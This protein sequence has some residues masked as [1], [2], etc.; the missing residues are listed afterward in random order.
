[1]KWIVSLILP[2]TLL[3]CASEESSPSALIAEQ[4]TVL[5]FQKEQL[6]ELWTGDVPQM[7]QQIHHQLPQSL[8]LPI[9][10]YHL[11]YDQYQQLY[12]ATPRLSK[13]PTTGV[14]PTTGNTA[15]VY[16]F[17]AD[18]ITAYGDSAVWQRI[19]PSVDS[20]VLFVFPNDARQQPVFE[21][22]LNGPPNAAALHSTLWLHLQDYKQPNH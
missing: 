19:M 12:I 9:G 17:K 13:T 15:T 20:I 8:P 21:R 22:N 2:F 14:Y 11:R 4:P 18:L 5:F 10:F 3:G 6:L 16:N 1:M 7:I